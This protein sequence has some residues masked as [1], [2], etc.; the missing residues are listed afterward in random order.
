M[1]PICG[2]VLM[3]DHHAMVQHKLTF[4][5]MREQRYYTARS[6]SPLLTH[7]GRDKMATISQTTMSNAFSLMKII[8]YLFEYHLNF[9]P[10]S[11]I[12]NI[13]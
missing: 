11:P 10:M 12:N 2:S 8:V 7:Q 5:L 3:D 6:H 1:V 9:V 13:P 4:P